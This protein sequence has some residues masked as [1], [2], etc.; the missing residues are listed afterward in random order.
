MH[1]MKAYGGHVPR[2][3][4]HTRHDVRFGDVNETENGAV[5]RTSPHNSTL[6]K[7]QT[8][9]GSIIVDNLNGVI[10]EL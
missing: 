2:G 3:N 8:D 5:E 10:D 4:W 9:A 7:L 1:V 6:T